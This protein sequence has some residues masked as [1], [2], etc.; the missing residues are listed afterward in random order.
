MMR[1]VKAE[2]RILCLCSCVRESIDL[3]LWGGLFLL[4]EHGCEQPSCTHLSSTRTIM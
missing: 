1:M 3:R 4:S 2:F